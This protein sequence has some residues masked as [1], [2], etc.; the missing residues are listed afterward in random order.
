MPPFPVVRFT[1]LIC[2]LLFLAAAAHAEPAPPVSA[3]EWGPYAQMV[4][5]SWLGKKGKRNYRVTVEWQEPGKTLIE[6]W[7][8]LDAA[9]ANVARNI[10]NTVSK[11]A[12]PGE[13]LVDTRGG[14]CN[15]TG[16][17]QGDGSLL[18]VCRTSL[19]KWPERLVGSGPAAIELQ[20]VKLEGGVVS[21]VVESVALAPEPSEAEKRRAVAAKA[22]PIEAADWGV[23]A[24]LAGRSW[25]AEYSGQHLEVAIEWVIPGV[26]LRERWLTSA[27]PGNDFINT[28]TRG[29]KKGELLMKLTRGN[30]SERIG[31]VQ[32]DGSLLFHCT[33]LF[34]MPMRNTASGPGVMEHYGLAYAA[35]ATTE[36]KLAQA[37]A[38]AAE[39]RRRQEQI[40][41][42]RS[43]AEQG[44][45]QAQFNLANRYAKGDGLAEDPAQADL[46]FRKA[47]ESGLVRA[48][49]HLGLLAFGSDTASHA[50]GVNWLRRAVAQGD[51]P[52][53]YYLGFLYKFGKGGVGQDYIE[54]ARLY[55]LAAEQGHAS[56]QVGL[57]ILYRNGEGVDQDSGQAL[58]WFEKAA[59]QGDEVA[60]LWMGDAFDKGWAGP[61]DPIR[62][63]GFYRQAADKGLAMAQE[64]LADLH[65]A[66]RGV[67]QDK[68]QA[69]NWYRKAAEQGRRFAQYKLG[70]AYHNG[71]GVARNEREA[72]GW[73]RKAADQGEVHAMSSLGF[74]YWTDNVAVADQWFRKAIAG[75][76][77]TA[78]QDLAILH[79]RVAENAADRQAMFSAVT[80]GFS[81]GFRSEWQAGQQQLARQAQM[82][83]EWQAMADRHDEEQEQQRIA[84]ENRKREA[85]ME[86]VRQLHAQQEAV[87]QQR[88]EEQARQ[89]SQQQQS[90][91]Q[92][93]ADEQARQQRKAEDDRRR[94]SAEA[95]RQ[96]QQEVEAERRRRD[97]VAQRER[98]D[99]ALQERT[100][101]LEETLR[102][103]Q[104]DA[105][106]RPVAYREGITLCS[107]PTNGG[108]AW[109]CQG[110][111]QNMSGDLEGQSGMVAVRQACGGGNIRSLGNVAGYR[112]F[113]C[114]YGIH[115]NPGDYPSNRDIPARLGVGHVPGRRTFYCNPTQVHAHCRE[116]G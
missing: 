91:E 11:G 46:W 23:Y 99:K 40:A 89:Q 36:E 55:R 39:A 95:E 42:E 32:A 79:Q 5:N 3:A 59:L 6:T 61:P 24:D 94:A 2:S 112:A 54:A 33:G 35:L 28:I 100:R 18:L 64:R 84:E 111:L 102:K 15:R 49:V 78:R 47:A 66:G 81:E 20:T 29:A 74:Y 97:E 108:R 80:D 69:F 4:G 75:G 105:R 104:E 12:K 10:Y 107:P 73:Y 30:C 90:E 113:G 63:A 57:G 45:A 43:A 88:A 48:Q 83:E 53:Q 65:D 60:V 38:A 98:A 14:R 16:H 41:A 101:Q 21:Q 92:R 1:A 13:L 56:A 7:T 110:P 71:A 8:D 96:R 93:K 50:E 58:A 70:Q 103:Q 87:R 115:P 31:S 67:P 76:H 37:E 77:P 109:L 17:I 9:Y 72:I 51:A 34:K 106:N 86:R 19:L 85:E 44:D 22:K 26:E 25:A 52:A 82:V 27:M 68:V 114:G 116:R 62:A